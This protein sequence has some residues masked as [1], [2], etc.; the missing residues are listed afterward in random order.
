M[1][2]VVIKKLYDSKINADPSC[3]YCENNC[4]DC[5]HF[6][7]Y[8][9]NANCFWKRL[10]SW[11][12]PLS[13]IKIDIYSWD[14]TESILFGFQIEE[15]IVEVLHYICLLAKNYIYTE[16]IHNNNN[17]C[18]YTFLLILKNKLEKYCSNMEDNEK[19]FEKFPFVL[20]NL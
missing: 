12:N 9:F 16:K 13:P 19:K 6:F 8:C 14:I 17:I 7:V 10:F 5:I 15:E 2:S 4:D 1:S 3:K 18:F 20:E 11:W